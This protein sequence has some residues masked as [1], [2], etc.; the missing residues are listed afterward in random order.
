MLEGGDTVQ[1]LVHG[2]SHRLVDGVRVVPGDMEGLVAVSPEQSVEFGLRYPGQDRRVGDL[3]AVEVQDRQDGTVPYRVEE[4][5]RVPGGGQWARLG[6]TV[7]DHAG[8]QEPRIVERG[9]VGVRERVTQL[10]ALVD[11][12]GGL[13]C[14]MTGDA[15]REGEL[16]EEAGH[17]GRVPR[18]VRVRLG[19]GALQP[20]VRHHGRPAVTGP[21]DTDRVQVPRLDDPVEVGV[22]EVQ[23]R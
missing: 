16:P 18:D 7:A 9:P 6:L 8:H 2:A 13:G 1:G 5:V 10:A 15:A 3:V 19:V 12:S 11:R 4:L 17:A 14:D 20:G 22:D 23:A 21:P